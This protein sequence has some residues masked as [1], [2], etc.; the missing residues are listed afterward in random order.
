MARRCA[1]NSCAARDKS[2][3][4]WAAGAWSPCRLAKA[5]RA[6]CR[7]VHKAVVTPC[8]DNG[9]NVVAASPAANHPSPPGDVSQLVAAPCRPGGDCAAKPALS[10]QRPMKRVCRTMSCHAA[11]LRDRPRGSRSASENH[12]RLIRRSGVSVANHQPVSTASTRLAS[13]GST[14]V[15]CCVNALVAA[16]SR[17]VWTRVEQRRATIAA[18]PLQSR[19]NR[20]CSVLPSA[21][22]SDQRPRSRTAPAAAADM[23]RAAVRCAASRSDMSNALRSIT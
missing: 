15:S 18:R 19:T 13:L 20:A 1:T 11:L 8:E 23:T 16:T 4:Y 10:S 22:G 17:S 7:P 9:S 14:L 5:A 6:A 3:V 12:I 2:A 21:R